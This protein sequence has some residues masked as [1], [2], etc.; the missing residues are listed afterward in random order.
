MSKVHKCDQCRRRFRGQGDWNVI[1]RAGVIVAYRCP[2]C[3]S[4]ENL[5]EASINE[6]FTDYSKMRNVRP[7]DPGWDE[8]MGQHIAAT[9][10]GVFREFLQSAA[11]SDDGLPADPYGLADETLRRLSETLGTPDDDTLGRARESMAEQMRTWLDEVTR[12]GE[13]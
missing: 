1:Y 12:G 7:G 8:A 10:E 5:A 13:S 6:V 9:A 4:P 11:A 2:D 3:Q